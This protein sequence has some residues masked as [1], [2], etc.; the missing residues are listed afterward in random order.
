MHLL[1]DDF[2]FKIHNY[3]CKKKF[4]VK[5]VE[6]LIPILLQFFC[7][8]LRA[9]LFR[10]NMNMYLQ[11]ISFPHNEWAQTVEILPYQI[12]NPNI[13]TKSIPWVLMSWQCKEP[14]HQQP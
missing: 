11:F 1:M 3:T 8:L 4:S 7:N 13:S 6:I 12:Q 9:K 14:G 10:R 5:N 2:F